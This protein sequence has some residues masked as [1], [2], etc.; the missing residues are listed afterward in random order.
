[1]G[2][3]RIDPLEFLVVIALISIVMTG[4]SWIVKFVIAFF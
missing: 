4:L 3:S 1:M 2:K